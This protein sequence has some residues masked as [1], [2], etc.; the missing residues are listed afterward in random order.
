MPTSVGPQWRMLPLSFGLIMS[1]VSDHRT[2]EHARLLTFSRQFGGHA[3]FPSLAR[4]IR[5]PKYFNRVCDLAFSVATA[6]Y[7][8]MGIVGYLM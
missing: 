6:F 5:E 4:D 1:G 8:F 2:V 7:L 3:V